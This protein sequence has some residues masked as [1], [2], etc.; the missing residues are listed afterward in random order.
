[1]GSASREALAAA[2]KALSGKLD[3]NAGA[4]LLSASALIG[5]SPALLATLADGSTD[6]TVRAQLVEKLFGSV[7]AGAR[8]VLSAAVV[9]SWSNPA[10]LLDGI[11]LLYTSR[12]V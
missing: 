5:G 2:L 7:S 1:M 6:G 9:Q 4:E 8:S 3:K 12:C 10:E 11:C